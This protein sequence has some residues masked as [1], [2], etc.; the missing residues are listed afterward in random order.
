MTQKKSFI[1]YCL[2][3]ISSIFLSISYSI[4]QRALDGGLIISNIIQYPENFNIMEIWANNSWTFL[5][6]FS[7][8]LL[9]L[10]FSI[11]NASRLILFFSTF[12]YSFGIY[13]TS[14]SIT[15]SSN[16]SLLI[17]FVIVFF[18]KNFGAI[19]Y[20]TLMFSEHTN[21]MMS[22]AIVTLIFGLISNKNYFAAGFFSIFLISLHSVIGLWISLILIFSL[23]IFKYFFK[24]K[25]DYKIFING[26]V[27]GSIVVLFSFIF[28]F[29]NLIDFKDFFDQDIYLSYMENWEAHRTNYGNLS[30]FNYLYCFLSFILFFFFF[31]SYLYFIKKNNLQNALMFLVLSLTIFLSAIIFF[32]YKLYPFLYPEIFV[33]A[34][35]T[36]F[37]LLHSVIG[38][39]II[40]SSIFLIIKNFCEKRNLNNFYSIALI[41]LILF[42]L[43]INFHKFRFSHYKNIAYL[44]NNFYLNIFK[45]DQKNKN[46]EFWLNIKN[47]NTNGFI[48]TSNETCRKTLRK[49]LKPVLLCVESIDNI[50]YL[51]NTAKKTKELIENVYDVSFKNPPIKNRGGIFGDIIKKNF[52]KKTFNQWDEL[53]SPYMIVGL[54]VPANWEIDLKPKF[55]GKD[56]IYY[57][58]VE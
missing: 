58:L 35:P 12:F 1:P 7:A 48:L 14:R 32:T 31:Y 49:A 36:R 37:F 34:M 8:L 47:E 42:G 25:I 6:Q 50:A 38:F 27:F 54:V 16:L 13:L 22:L 10:D 40:I 17:C 21:G 4:E 43:S 39:P 29:N 41:F 57:S 30:K 15:L 26:M 11:I 46:Y 51:P 56:Y 33:R 23:F 24:H 9:K 55:I 2:I 44:F 28:Y 45:N 5:F 18:Q 3:F 53:K 20:P 52:E 19:D